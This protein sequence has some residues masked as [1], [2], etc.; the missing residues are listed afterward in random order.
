MQSEQPTGPQ[1]AGDE[2]VV[3]ALPPDTDVLIVDD[4]AQ[5]V[6]L[7]QAYLEDLGGEVRTAGD[8]AAA[9]E[10]IAEQVPH[11]ILLDVM[12]P[13]MSGYQVLERLRAD[14]TTKDVPVVVV[15][16]LSEVGDVERALELGADDFL[17]KPVARVELQARVRSLVRHSRRA[18]DSEAELRRL[19]GEAG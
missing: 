8:G 6:E 12:M 18:A 3:E 16:A 14:A 15:T 5:N 1:D 11:I 19:R 4:N 9:F 7:L 13:R 17:T 2:G 10:A